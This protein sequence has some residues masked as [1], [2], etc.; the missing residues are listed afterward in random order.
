[1]LPGRVAGARERRARNGA[2]GSRAS[3]AGTRP[4]RDPPDPERK[5]CGVARELTVATQARAALVL[6]WIHATAAYA[7]QASK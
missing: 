5:Q 4:A 3:D 1:M 7:L 2:A 6:A